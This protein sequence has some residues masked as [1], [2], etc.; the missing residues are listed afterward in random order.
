[1][2]QDVLAVTWAGQ[3]GSEVRARYAIDAA[4]PVIRE[5][6]VKKSGGQWA[7]IG[8]NLTPEYHVL[9]G[10]RRFSTQQA[11]PLRAAGIP[12]TADVISKNR[13]YAFWDA[14]LVLPDGP[15]MHEAQAARPPRAVPDPYAP[16]APLP[17]PRVQ[18]YNAG[19]GL[20]PLPLAGRNIGEPRSG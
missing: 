19:G 13:W 9:S 1:M 4:Q 18:T 11:D 3:G 12:L 10:I 17:P 14:P 20:P 5:L 7:V 6:A 15:E 16:Q 2:E 8:Q